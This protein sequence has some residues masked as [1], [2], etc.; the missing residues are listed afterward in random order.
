MFVCVPEPV[1]HT[2]RGK[3]SSN[4]PLITSSE[5]LTIACEI[6]LSND[7]DLKLTI[8][9]AFLMIAIAFIISK[10]TLYLADFKVF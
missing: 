2:L 10:G 7:L 5:A 1:C 4:L 8:A 6:F 3:L 9:A